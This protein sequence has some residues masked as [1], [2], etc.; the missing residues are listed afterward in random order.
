[1]LGSVTLLVRKAFRLV[2]AVFR[3]LHAAR[4]G[5]GQ[6]L[7]VIRLLAVVIG[8]VLRTLRRFRISLRRRQFVLALLLCK[9]LLARLLARGALR[10]LGR[11]LRALDR[12]LLVALLSVLQTLFVVERQLFLANLLAYFTL[13]VARFV[14]AVIDEES[15][16]AIVLLDPIEIV[17]LR[18]ADVQRLLARGERICIGSGLRCASIDCA[19]CTDHTIRPICRHARCRLRGIAIVLCTRFVERRLGNRRTRVDGLRCLRHDRRADTRT[20]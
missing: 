11:V 7:L 2:L 15:A 6:F 9:R 12:G 17:I 20:G 4:G 1:M 3:V 19:T 5:I 13:G 10:R 14:Q 16:V 18:A 8:L